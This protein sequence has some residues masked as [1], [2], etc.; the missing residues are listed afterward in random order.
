MWNGGKRFCEGNLGCQREKR[1][2]ATKN[3]G[4]KNPEKISSNLGWG[5]FFFLYFIFGFRKNQTKQNKKITK[6]NVK[7][8]T[9]FDFAKLWIV[10]I[11]HINGFAVTV[12][13]ERL[14]SAIP[15]QITEFPYCFIICN[16]T[17]ES[18]SPSKLAG[19]KIFQLWMDRL[20]FHHRNRP[21]L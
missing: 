18:S 15:A 20:G 14:T 3:K 13:A 5:F 1:S 6:K 19:S 21:L 4:K 11:T 17:K 7:L 12:L 16:Q 8:G 2:K 10:E 9:F